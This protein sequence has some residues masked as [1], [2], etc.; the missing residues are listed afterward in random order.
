M[1]KQSMGLYLKPAGKLFGFLLLAATALVIALPASAY[2]AD[3]TVNDEAELE[4]AVAAAPATPYAIE[5]GSDI[6]LASTRASLDIPAGTDITL[7]GDHLL[8]GADGQDT[9]TVEGTL[10][11]DGITVTHLT[12]EFGRGALVQPGGTLTLSSG[13][14]SGNTLFSPYL[15]GGLGGGVDNHGTFTMEGG[16]I[17][18]NGAYNGGGVYNSD[19]GTFTMAGGEIS[20][21]RATYMGGGVCNGA[22][23]FTM[24]GGTISGNGATFGGGVGGAF[25]MEDGTISGNTAV[26]GA[27]VYVDG[28]FTMSDGTISDNAASRS[29]GGVYNNA[30][31]FTM[32]DG[33]IS[34]NTATD[35]GGGV[36][37]IDA[38]V[39]ENGT[40]SGNMAADGGGVYNDAG[41]FTMKGGTISG[42]TAS[43]S[44]TSSGGGVF[45]DDGVFTMQAG[46][47]SRNVSDVWGGGVDND[48]GT[49]IMDDGIISGN[50]AFVG[51]GVFNWDTFT[52]WGGTISD[53]TAQGSNSDGGGVFNWGIFAMNNGKVSGNTA[54][55]GG[56]VFSLGIVFVEAGEVSANTAAGDGGGIFTSA[57]T[58]LEVGAAAVFS[59]NKAQAS[60]DRDPADDEFYAT[61]IH[62]TVWTSPFTQGYNNYDINYTGPSGATVTVAFDGNSGVVLPA[63]LSRTVNVGSSLGSDMPPD[64]TRD[65]YTFTGWNTAADGSGTAFTSSTVVDA[66]ITV[67]AQWAAKGEPIEP[68]IPPTGDDAFRLYGTSALG[69]LLAST[70]LI[71]AY[72][73]S[74]RKRAP[75]R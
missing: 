18:D 57:Y 75:G 11:L 6:D 43:G 74:R 27:G 44:D 24:E 56:G 48:F 71:V 31:A 28:A 60:Y 55:F 21:N 41:A 29:G 65:G 14:V 54:S 58:S 19:S 50:T 13:T 73:A 33:T 37:N 72:G 10:T 45:T 16:E 2:A 38:F 26:S 20:S 22:G 52:M 1:P 51:G 35:G 47:I 61:Q 12:G 46:E 63:D 9:I 42:N 66:D 4:A 34:E 64:P 7:S 3:I 67:Y 32:K 40:I 39:M 62:G 53:N 5:L 23:T 68:V 69:L 25:T 30:G 70:G 8:T 15:I 49:F 17:S 36:Y 59:D